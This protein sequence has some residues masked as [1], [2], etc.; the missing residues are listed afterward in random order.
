VWRAQ[1]RAQVA[2]E[3]WQ[4]F[5]T[6]AERAIAQGYFQSKSFYIDGITDI[7]CPVMND[8]TCIAALT[9]PFIKVGDGIEI[10]DAVARMKATARQLSK[11]LGA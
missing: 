2:P 4:V 9:M 6:Q 8:V 3:E 5:E 10:D 7:A 11:S 1:L